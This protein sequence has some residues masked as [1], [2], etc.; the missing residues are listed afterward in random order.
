MTMIVNVYFFT[1]R[2]G[3]QAKRKHIPPAGCRAAKIFSRP[4]TRVTDVPERPIR[5]VPQR[6][7]MELQIDMTQ[8]VSN[9]EEWKANENKHS[10]SEKMSCHIHYEPHG[11]ASGV[12]TSDLNMLDSLVNWCHQTSSEDKT[13]PGKHC[14]STSPSKIMN[15]Y[16]QAQNRS[17]LGFLEVDTTTAMNKFIQDLRTFITAL[18]MT[19]TKTAWWTMPIATMLC[20]PWAFCTV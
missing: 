2:Q 18:T 16:Y 13:S 1:L 14:S 19:F 3:L 20:P 15:Q 9:G 11:S 6:H 4:V 12:K 17:C 10:D 5:P 7:Q 8:M